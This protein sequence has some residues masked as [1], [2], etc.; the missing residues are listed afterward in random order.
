MQ[1]ERAARKPADACDEKFHLVLTRAGRVDFLEDFAQAVLVFPIRIVG[2][3]TPHVADIPDVIANAV[4]FDVSVVQFFTTEL[5]A[6][7]NGFEHRT[8]RVAAAAML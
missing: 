7:F 2:L 8:I 3:K 1:S 5:L 4:V 6:D